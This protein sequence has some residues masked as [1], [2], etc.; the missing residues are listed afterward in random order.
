M[1]K[2]I[3]T[4][5]TS[6]AFDAS[7]EDVFAAW[8]QPAR[9]RA[10]FAP[11]LGE[12]T[13]VEVNAGV[14]GTLAITQM[15]ED[16]EV[17]HIGVFQQVI[18]PRRLIFSWTVEGDDGEDRIIVDITPRGDG[19]EVT[20]SYELDEEWAEFAADSELA[21]GVMLE[22]MAQDLAQR[23]ELPEMAE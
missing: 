15:R 13:Q 22:A 5:Q 8:V 10:W 4:A 19:C 17:T 23:P 9:I 21:W 18:H 14:G 2:P 1:E 11:G 7:A 6:R 12:V 16:G 20:L 3:V